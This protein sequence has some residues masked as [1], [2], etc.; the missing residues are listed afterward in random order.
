MNAEEEIKEVIDMVNS[1]TET[2]VSRDGSL[3]GQISSKTFED[4]K[5]FSLPNDRNVSTATF[6][7]G[8]E[9][10]F[11]F[12]LTEGIKPVE[13]ATSQSI[14]TKEK[15]KDFALTQLEVLKKEKKLND[16]V[17]YDEELGCFKL[18]NDSG[19]E[20]YFSLNGKEIESLK[21]YTLSLCLLISQTPT[22]LSSSLPA[23]SF[24]GNIESSLRAYESFVLF[25]EQN[26]ATFITAETFLSEIEKHMSTVKTNIQTQ[27]TNLLK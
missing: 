5:C 16:K 26:E 2:I 12:S 22:I 23:K 7:N 10:K 25:A 18:K 19:N 11:S 13:E 3:S 17:K 9:R 8:E 14:K 1:E 20:I 4:I 27:E 24:N 15:I 21:H 6:K